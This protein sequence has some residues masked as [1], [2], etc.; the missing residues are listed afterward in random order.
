MTRIEVLGCSAGG[1]LWCLPYVIEPS[2]KLTK[3]CKRRAEVKQ[4]LESQKN[5]M[6]DEYCM[7]QLC[8]F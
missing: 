1:F 2:A 7:H 5:C 8:G 6:D 4:R 3:F